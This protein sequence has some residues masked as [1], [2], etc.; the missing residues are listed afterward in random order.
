LSNS[1]NGIFK[2][3]VVDLVA[4]ANHSLKLTENTAGFSA[5]RYE[6]TK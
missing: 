1:A 5:A 2:V 6:F 4:L 3:A